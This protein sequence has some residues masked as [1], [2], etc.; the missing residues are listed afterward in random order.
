MHEHMRI[1]IA[2]D[3]SGYADAALDDLRWAG[4]TGFSVLREGHPQR[5]L[6]EE[7]ARWGADGVFV[8][9]R[10]L[11]QVKRFLL[12]SV[13]AAMA[14][15]AHCSVEVVRTAAEQGGERVKSGEVLSISGERLILRG[16][17]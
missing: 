8:G 12:G 7:I 1:L 11:G 5:A 2:Y 4:L 17:T 16:A 13:S 3:G 6:L 15:R 10:G 9:S 14:M